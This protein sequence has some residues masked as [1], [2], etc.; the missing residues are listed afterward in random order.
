MVTRIKRVAQFLFDNAEV[1]AEY[2]RQ[3]DNF[4]TVELDLRY[5][6]CMRDIP[7]LDIELMLYDETSGL[8]DLKDH[9]ITKERFIQLQ[10]MI[11]EDSGAVPLPEPV[12]VRDTLEPADEKREEAYNDSPEIDT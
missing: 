3:S 8:N 1:I 7:E 11:N 2:L 6:K 4:R 9:L 12:E 5:H 10:Q